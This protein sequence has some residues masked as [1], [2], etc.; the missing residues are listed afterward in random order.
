[1]HTL[2]KASKLNFCGN[3]E[4]TEFYSGKAD[5]VVT[6]GFSGNIGLKVAEGTANVI[7]SSLRETFKNSIWGEDTWFLGEAFATEAGKGEV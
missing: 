3:I 6:D 2:L 5:V 4:G 7:N 1:M